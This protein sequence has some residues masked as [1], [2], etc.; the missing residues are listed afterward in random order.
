MTILIFSAGNNDGHSKALLSMTIWMAVVSVNEATPP[1]AVSRQFLP[2]TLKMGR[3]RS[4]VRGIHAALNIRGGD[5]VLGRQGKAEG[6]GDRQPEDGEVFSTEAAESGVEEQ[7]Y[8]YEYEYF[9]VDDAEGGNDDVEYEN[10]TEEGNIDDP[11][12]DQYEDDELTKVDDKYSGHGIADDVSLGRNDKSFWG[13]AKRR[14][15]ENIK[16]GL[17]I[18]E[19]NDER[20]TAQITEVTESRGLIQVEDGGNDD[21]EDGGDLFTTPI[22]T[23]NQNDVRSPRKSQMVNMIHSNKDS[24]NGDN[25]LDHRMEDYLKENEYED[26]GNV[27]EVDDNDEYSSDLYENPIPNVKAAKSQPNFITRKT[28]KSSKENNSRW[29]D[30]PSQMAEKI[31]SKKKQWRHKSSSNAS[32]ISLPFY[33]G[34]PPRSFSI[35]FC[36]GKTLT[37]DW[38][39]SLSSTLTVVIQ[40]ITCNVA[41]TMSTWM[42]TS[43]LLVCNTFD[44]LWYGPVDGVTTT[45][46]ATREGGL[47]CLLMSAPVIGMSSVIILGMLSVLISRRWSETSS[48]D[49]SMKD[50][51]VRTDDDEDE[52]DP[53]VEEELNFLHRDFDAANPSSKERIAKSITKPKRLLSKLGRSDDRLKSRRGQ[54][55]FTIKSIQTW[56]K[57]R[58]SQQTIAIIEPQHL[59]N[60]LQPLGQEI[61]RLQKQLAV[62]EQERAILCQD[63]QHL[64]DKLQRV[65]HEARKIISKNQRL[66]KEASMAD[67]FLS[68]AVQVE[69]RKSNDELGKVRESMKGALERERM[70]MRGRIEGSEQGN[71]NIQGQNDL[72]IRKAQ[73][74]RI[75]DGVKIVREID[76]DRE[77]DDDRNWTAM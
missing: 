44:F 21:E 56:W 69:R 51:G 73:N 48:E 20:S 47:S 23:A 42:S 16:S 60:Q 63:V 68:R 27:E 18:D 52:N 11:D 37:S 26:N 1:T 15:K 28:S 32:F 72:D 70:L 8:E 17:D 39:S 24:D 50:K 30:H 29:W 10:Y 7:E 53:S 65:Q 35:R 40:T 64:Q 59:R 6:R 14:T 41:S 12:Y 74:T 67:Q 49:R 66:E 3:R 22:P 19:S 38:L 31:P 71:M 33:S 54:R 58:P 13:W 46:I 61:S 2:Q 76:L 77:D 75:L 45:G 43:W 57:E 5:W 4:P 25:E 36:N 9:E 55:Q 34:G 62:S